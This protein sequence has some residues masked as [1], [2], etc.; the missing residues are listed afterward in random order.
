[1]T[2]AIII[3]E[4]IK[5]FFDMSFLLWVISTGNISY[6]YALPGDSKKC[7][8]D[9]C[10]DLYSITVRWIFNDKASLA[11]AGRINIY[12]YEAWIYIF[13][14]LYHIMVVFHYLFHIGQRGQLFA[15]RIMHTVVIYGAGNPFSERMGFGLYPNQRRKDYQKC[16]NDPSLFTCFVHNIHPI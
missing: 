5:V 12:P 1:M 3:T 9:Q 15:A 14:L 16:Q 10:F 2:I 4:K 11:G 13:N 7:F 6:V 8:A